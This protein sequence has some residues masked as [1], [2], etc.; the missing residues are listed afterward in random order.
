MLCKAAECFSINYIAQTIIINNTEYIGFHSL[1]V[2]GMANIKQT[3]IMKLQQ[4]LE[5]PHCMQ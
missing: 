3:Q 2:G 4:N 5:L 1:G